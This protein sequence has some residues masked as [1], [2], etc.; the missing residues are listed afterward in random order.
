MIRIIITI[1]VINLIGDS[2]NMIKVLK[3]M[4]L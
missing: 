4:S 3:N 1:P 2:R